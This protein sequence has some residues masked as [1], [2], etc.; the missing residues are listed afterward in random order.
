MGHGWDARMWWPLMPALTE[1]YRVIRFDNRGVGR[2]RWDGRPFLI[3]DLADD[4]FAVMDAAGVDRAHVYGMSMGGLTVQEMALRRPARVASLVLGCTGAFDKA[5][6]S[7][8]DG[9]KAQIPFKT[10]M[11]LFK[12]ALYGPLADPAAIKEDLRL[13]DDATTPKAG[14]L[15][16]TRAINVSVTLHQVPQITAPT[17][18]IH[19][20]NDRAIKLAMGQQLAATIP[21]AELCVLERAGHN[22]LADKDRASDAALLA[23]LDKQPRIGD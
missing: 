21:G 11:K 15:A 9:L 23:F 18:V 22:Y 2:T 6:G 4:A 14:L 10:A 20:T 19:G 13:M 8:L 3:E 17:L 5:R 12:S 1:R 16:Q 7:W